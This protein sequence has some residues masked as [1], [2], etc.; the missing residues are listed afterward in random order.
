[1]GEDKGG[2]GKR[3]EISSLS[4]AQRLKLLQGASGIYFFFITYGKLQ[5]RIFLFTGADGRK[6]T[7]V[8]FLQ[9][10]DALANVLVG[11]VGRR[12]E[13]ITPGLPQPLLL[14]SGLGQVVSKYCLSA[15]LAAGLSFPVATLA[16]SAKMAPVMVGSL[17]LGGASFSRRQIAQASAIVGGTSLVTLCEGKGSSGRSSALGLLLILVALA[18]DGMVGGVQKRLKVDAKA[19]MQEVRGYD[20]MFWTNVYMAA[21]AFVAA[22]AR[23]ELRQGLAFC[24][25]NPSMYG[26]ILKFAVC[27]AMG[28]AC[29]F[30]TIAQFDSV[31]CTAITTT[32]KL[33]SVL[34]SLADGDKS[35]PPLGWLG[36]GVAGAGIVGEVI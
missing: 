36:L 28:Q 4:P 2:G 34:L 5:E 21:A 26:Q 13:G 19:R 18:C 14:Y 16:K 15:S 8:W 20:L 32:R 27:G 30:Y 11:G 6:F 9:L 12:F 17:V 1:M 7:A 10:V 25:A 3:K 33:A 29:I 31:V 35:L 22:A 23:R 24:R